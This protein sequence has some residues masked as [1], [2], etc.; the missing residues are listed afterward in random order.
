MEN[1]SRNRLIVSDVKEAVGKGK[2][3]IILTERADH[4]RIL[5]EKLNADYKNVITLTGKMSVKEK[6]EAM[7]KLREVPENEPL[8]VIAT[9]KYVGEGFDF[10]RLDTLFIVMPISWRGKVAQYA[11][12]L[13]RLYEGKK[14]A[15]IYDYVDV[16]IPVLER[17]YHKRIKTYADLG[18]KTRPL[19]QPIEKVSI[20]HDGRSFL[21]VYNN[22]ISNARKEIV[23]VSPYMRRNRLVSMVKVLS[24][25]AL[26]GVS[27][28][29][30]TRPQEDFKESERSVLSENIEY[31]KSANINI[32]LKSK[33]HQKF[34]VI[35]GN[36]VWY[37]SVNF[38]SFGKSEESV[39]RFDSF[40][41]GG[42]LLGMI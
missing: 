10:P 39:M 30:V 22:D 29:V 1:E 41:I 25:A 40:E 24:G 8:I 36:T 4:V 12:R 26:N 19:E 20:I 21:P 33:I 18:Y 32:I 11:G 7:L 38:L 17:M 35:D 34:T 5:S 2:T 16:H 37:G 9:G 15:L 3:P 42:E 28:T 23:I 31:L 6:R 14:E 27:I 13:H